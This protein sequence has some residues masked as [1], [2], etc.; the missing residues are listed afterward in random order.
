MPVL[1]I[2]SAIIG[3]QLSSTRAPSL[4][5]SSPRFNISSRVNKPEEIVSVRVLE[6]SEEL[7][8]NR[9]EFREIPMHSFLVP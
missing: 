1:R 3:F 7:P 8:E 2:S 6:I 5:L 4:Y 9:T